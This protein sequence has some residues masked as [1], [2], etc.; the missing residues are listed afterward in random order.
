LI[1]KSAFKTLARLCARTLFRKR[2]S[3]GARRLA[4]WTR[5]PARTPRSRRGAPT[6]PAPTRRRRG[7]LK[8][9]CGDDT[10][11]CAPHCYTCASEPPA[12]P[13]P[14]FIVPLTRR[15]A[16]AMAEA[17]RRHLHRRSGGPKKK[18]KNQSTVQFRRRQTKLTSQLS[19]RLLSAHLRVLIDDDNYAVS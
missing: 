6:T 3:A 7:G 1:G 2:R 4:A 19:G 11:M 14:S 13:S 17:A 15:E 12:L 5:L 8:V 16:P 18:K 9:A 10:T